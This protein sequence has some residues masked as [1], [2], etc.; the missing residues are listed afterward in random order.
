MDQR[1][2]KIL[3][4]TYWS[5]AGWKPDRDR[6]ISSDDFRYAKSK[7]V[8]FDMARIDHDET[9]VRLRRAVAKL[10]RRR[11]ADAF[12]A[13]LSSRRLDLRSALGS[14]AVFEHL[15]VHAPAGGTQCA[16]CGLYWRSSEAVDLNV[17]NFERHK[18]AGVRHDQPLYAALD[19][20][21]FLAEPAT[22][23]SSEDIR[24]FREMIAAL[25]TAAPTVTAG[26][27]HKCFT[28][29]LKGNKAERDVVVAILGF[30]G[31]LE[32]QDHPGFSRSF[33]PYQER[34]LPNR[35]FVDMAYPACWW[36]R[37][38]GLRAE[39]LHDYFGHVL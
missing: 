36:H 9:L 6:R 2:L 16:T 28:G 10:N 14:F 25:E 17:F 11:V 24:I 1:A 4:D 38:A 34:T 21:L 20:E 39:A 23:P 32:T 15:P 31:V 7:G 19:L 8:M 22:H 13:S 27:L 29:V 5:P 12:L 37:E 26:T 30:C 18:W 33:I 3:F 35:R